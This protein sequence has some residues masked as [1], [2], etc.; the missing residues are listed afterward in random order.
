M[1]SKRG[2]TAL[3]AV[4]V[5]AF[6]PLAANAA[7]AEPGMVVVVGRVLDETGA[8]V[9]NA[10]VS[11]QAKGVTTGSAPTTTT[12]A[13]G[14]YRLPDLAPGEYSLQAT[15]P[16]FAVTTKK[17]ALKAGERS[18]DLTLSPGGISE[19]VTVSVTR[20]VESIAG[21]PAA[22]TLVEKEQ[23]AEQILMTKNLSDAL[24]NLVQG[25]A[26]GSQS[27]SVFGQS[28][29]GRKV[30][31]LIDG[32]PQSTTRNVSRDLT[33][34]DPSA[35][36][37]VEVLRG[38]TA[39]YGDGATGGVISI[40]TL[41]PGDGRPLLNTEIGE[42]NSLKHPEGSF[43][44][45]LRQSVAQKV[46]RFDYSLS[47]SFERV[48]GHFD[49]E[50]DRIPPDPHGQGGPGETR[51]WN[52]FAKLGAEI[53]PNQRL[54]LSANVF[55][56]LQDTRYANDPAVQLLP[57]GAA[58]SRVREGLVTE[59][60]V[61]TDNR[62]V[63]LDYTHKD[64]AGWRLQGQGYY[65]DYLTFFGG[66]DQR[67]NNLV[68][69]IT[70]SYLD[71][72]KWGGRLSMESPLLW[73][74]G[75]KLVTGADYS[76][77]LTSQPVKMIDPV[78]YDRSGG[79]VFAPVSDRDWVPPIGL[80]SLGVFAEIDW[81][82]NAR[83]QLRAGARFE[84]I[85]SDIDD[86]TTIIGNFLRGGHLEYQ[87]VQFN[88]GVVFH[89][90]DKLQVFSSFAQGF[91]IPD[92]G[93]VLR[94]ASAGS[95]VATL[96]FEAQKVNNYEVGLRGQWDAVQPSLAAYY[97]TSELGISSGGFNQPVVRAP[98][99]TWGFEAS[100]DARVGERLGAGAAVTWMEGKTD[101]NLD[102]VYTYLNTFRIQPLKVT[103]YIGHQ[104]LDRWHN[105]LQVFYSG[106]R[107]RFPGSRLFG[108]FPVRSY[109][110][111]DFLSR[112]DL[113][114]G[115]LRIGVENLLNNQ[116]FVRDSQLF[117]TGTNSSYTAARGA[118]L[119]IAYSF[120]WGAGA[121]ANP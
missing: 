41:P 88:A 109:T 11:V 21:I 34:I 119:N 72:E 94:G 93:L 44:G 29:R 23:L 74:K 77:E 102:G 111:I 73:S 98:E 22:I 107:N 3:L 76:S 84:H 18:V 43:G 38:A 16:G 6:G 47:A 112:I 39:L 13:E 4:V 28:L 67:R 64:I 26:A 71:S 96:P 55:D 37:R 49:G 90:A 87:D 113:G 75:P 54:Q 66:S 92:I 56:S 30:L 36:D 10:T 82:L 91:S 121:R 60:G 2:Y 57:L 15:A 105:R 42:S 101:P 106:E 51:T 53:A 110:T 116:Y 100:L 85:T 17:V 27:M 103:G 33:T 40:L 59:Q 70:Q 63:S 20:S 86:F 89:A 12:N 48:G 61:S 31:V 58:K 50:G 45:S 115:A 52:L 14:R 120:R 65:R 9:A 35:I 25:L 62:Q 83:W 80:D 24:G 79:L 5:A 104:T 108:E 19:E 78:A 1:R 69:A 8:V 32:V 46:G 81:P 97:A 114:P 7:P 117:R 68:R 95:S 118:A 99:R